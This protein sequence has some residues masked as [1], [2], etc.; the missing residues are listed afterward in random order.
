MENNK[1]WQ[2]REKLGP[3]YSAGR[4]V[5]WCSHLGKMLGIFQNIK[6]RVILSGNS[7]PKY[8]KN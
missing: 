8:S 1:C 2:A 5:K 7:T 4:I 6:H 3:S